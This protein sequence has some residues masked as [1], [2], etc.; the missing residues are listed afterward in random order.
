MHNAQ[1]STVLSS[2]EQMLGNPKTLARVCQ[3]QCNVAEEV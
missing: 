2:M 3:Q 1:L